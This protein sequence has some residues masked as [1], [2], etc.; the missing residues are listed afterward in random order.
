MGIHVLTRDIP[1]VPA[2]TR[3]NPWDFPLATRWGPI[4]LHCM[5]RNS[6]FTI[7]HIRRCFFLELSCFFNDTNGVG[8]LISGFFAFSKSTLIM[9]M[10][11]V[12]GLLKP[13]LENFEHYFASVWDECSCAVVWTFFGTSWLIFLYENRN[14]RFGCGAWRK[15]KKIAL[16]LVLRH[17]VDGMGKGI[18]RNKR[19][20]DVC[21]GELSLLSQLF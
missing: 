20:H 17:S 11:M 3:E 5:Q 19:N 7:K 4:P 1:H 16:I 18:L 9:W 21:F 13:G 15:N 2:A 12:H 10:F 6:V 8:S 14:P